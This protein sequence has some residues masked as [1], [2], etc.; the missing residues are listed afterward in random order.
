MPIVYFTSIIVF[1]TALNKKFSPQC[2]YTIFSCTKLNNFSVFFKSIVFRRYRDKILTMEI[3]DRTEN[4]KE[5]G[6]VDRQ[7]RN[8]HLKQLGRSCSSDLFSFVNTYYYYYYY[9]N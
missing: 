2:I 7:V 4:V 9:N 5:K 1:A 6:S 3:D 8:C